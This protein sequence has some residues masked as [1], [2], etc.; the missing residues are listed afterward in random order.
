MVRDQNTRGLSWIIRLKVAGNKPIFVK[1]RLFSHP[2]LKL[3]IS[4]KTPHMSQEHITL[5]AN[6]SYMGLPDISC[7]NSLAPGRFQFNFRCGWGISYE[8]ALRWMALDLTDDKS[9]LVQVMAW[10]RQATSD[11]LSQ[12]W[13]RPMSPKASLGLNELTR[14]EIKAE[15][16]HLLAIYE[17]IIELHVWSLYVHQHAILFIVW[18]QLQ[19]LCETQF[20][21]FAFRHT[22]SRH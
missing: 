20:F 6:E 18:Q 7:F 12:Y 10:C 8:I 13:P 9:T 19:K 3:W 22:R 17:G 4:Y 14:H 2:W 5:G 16:G 11:Y 21:I 15:F 1:K